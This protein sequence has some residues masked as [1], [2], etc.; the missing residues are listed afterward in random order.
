MAKKRSNSFQKK[1]KT[2]GIY[3]RKRG[4]AKIEGYLNVLKRIKLKVYKTRRPYIRGIL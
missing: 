1:K 2:N 3:G 4:R